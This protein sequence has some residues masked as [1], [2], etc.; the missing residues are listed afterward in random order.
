MAKPRLTKAGR[1]ELCI[2][3][4]LLPKRIFLT[5]D[6]E[7]EAERYG[8]E[9]YSLLRAGVLPAGLLAAATTAPKAELQSDTKLTAL[10]QKWRNTGRLS[11]TDDALLG[12]LLSDKKI[13][14]C[15]LSELSYQ[16]AEDWINHLKRVRVLAP[17]SIRQ[18]VQALGKVL[19]WYIRSNPET[20]SVNPL[21]LLPRGYSVYT[22]QDA[23]VLKV[24]GLEVRR[25]VVRDRRLH[26]GEFEAI[27]EVLAGKQRGDKQ[28]P[29]TLPDGDA[30]L[31]MFQLIV[32]SGCRMREA[33]TLRKE[34]VNMLAR[35]MR[36][37]TTKQRNGHIAFRD[38]PIRPELYSVLRDYMTP[39]PGLLF[40][41]WDGD[42]E[43]LGKTTG[44]LSQRFATVFAYVPCDSLTEHDLRHTAT[45]E[46]FEL[47]DDAGQWMFRSEEIN[48]IMGW[49][50]G[51]A[52]AT[53]YASFRGIDLANR[54]WAGVK[55]D[56]E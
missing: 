44:K 3:H 19:D 26:P 20:K 42:Q 25:D 38:V 29:L 31:V 41:F 35:M 45:C 49:K 50:P 32:R 46:W 11:K 18:R 51:S 37:Q 2:Q 12:W 23:K 48:K 5:F 24:D 17:S 6:S 39:G 56:Q 16:W 34:N 47:K 1:Y 4:K 28:R 40:P 9:A 55:Q 30:M 21:R 15:K 27:C 8:K 36:V 13:A 22:D 7:D 53:R 10:M 14:D 33:Y 54:L 43:T 52:M